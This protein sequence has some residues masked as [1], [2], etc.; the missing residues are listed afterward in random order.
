MKNLD[1]IL[2]YF[3]NMI[4]ENLANIFNQNPVIWDK[5][6]EIRIRDGRPIILK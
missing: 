4:Y 6:Q 2:K 5:L 1:E 3:P